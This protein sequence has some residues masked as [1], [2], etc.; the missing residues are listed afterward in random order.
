MH[1]SLLLITHWMSQAESFLSVALLN[2]FST[3]AQVMLM[4]CWNLKDLTAWG[5]C[6]TISWP[7]NQKEC[8]A[9]RAITGRFISYLWGEN[10]RICNT[11]NCLEFNKSLQIQGIKCTIERMR[12]DLL[13]S[14]DLVKIEKESV[15][16]GSKMKMNNIKKCY[17]NILTF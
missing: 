3:A 11:G 16:I 7:E 17:N 10:K 5:N 14:F 9:R 4:Y 6:S 1:T 2:A 12:I 13:N 15:E 8:S